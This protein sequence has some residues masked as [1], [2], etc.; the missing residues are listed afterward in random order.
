MTARDEVKRSDLERGPKKTPPKRRA[1]A[2]AGVT[3][4]AVLRYL[5]RVCGVNVEQ[6]RN[7][8]LSPENRKTIARLGNGKFPLGN[9]CT[10][11]VVNEVVV[12]IVPTR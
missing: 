9:G 6:V 5:E 11:V 3:D 4:H 2:P 8:I 1:A 12:T 7:M 10:A